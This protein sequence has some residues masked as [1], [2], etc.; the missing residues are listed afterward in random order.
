MPSP[1]ANAAFYFAGH[2]FRTAGDMV[3]GRQSASGGLLK[4][5][6]RHG[7]TET[8]CGYVD[9]PAGQKEFL[10]FGTE[11]GAPPDR[12][13]TYLPLQVA[14]LA[15]I[16]TLF[17]PGP[18]LGPLAWMRRQFDPAGFNLVGITHTVSD[19][20]ALDAL[21][22]LLVAPLEPWDA[23]VCTSASVEAVVRRVLDD[24]AGYLEE[25][26]GRRPTLPR[27]PII[28]LGV[29]A[30]ALAARGGN[31][32]VRADLR[33]RMNIANE[34]IAILYAGR[35]DHVE[36]ANP[37]P[38]LLAAEWAAKASVRKLHL[39]QAGQ[40]STPEMAA[41]FKKAATALA[42]GVTH[43]FVDGA[44]TELYEGVWAAAD[45]FISL[46]DNIQESFGLTPV[47]AMAAGLPC[48]VS[49]WNG[50]R[51]TVLDG[52]QGFTVPSA[53]PPPGAGREL[54]Y[55]FGAGFA[56]H[57]AFAGAASQSTAVDPARAAEAL[58]RLIEDADLRG[59]MA[60]AGRNRACDVFDWHHVVRRHQDLWAELSE[61]RAAAAT[62]ATG[63]PAWP[64]RPDP[65]DVFR[66]H[67][68]LRLAGDTE[69]HAGTNTDAKTLATLRNA[70]LAVPLGAML[71]D[72]RETEALLARIAERA[73]VSVAD[74]AQDV[75]EDNNV[76][77]YLT[78]GWL[79]KMGLVIA[80]PSLKAD[81]DTDT[82]TP[83]PFGR[84]SSWK[85][86]A[87]D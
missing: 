6:I 20:F 38:M 49:D 13:R 87:G 40:A 1:A 34:D 23:L 19:T 10:A 37:V 14:R 2:N 43:H 26:F 74:L 65:F 71:L 31:S 53:A 8:I 24:W 15:E 55:F 41:A 80:R 60:T 52:K 57:A 32:A 7:G 33:R 22:E 66:D 78:L 46:S 47:E 50:Y 5:F 28:P 18:G 16:G 85:T 61:S 81:T 48:V 68:T 39:I 64:L 30:D 3:V 72:D 82:G 17:R 27:L 9:G 83:L 45:I 62:P 4:G 63:G 35:L 70:E 77:F 51:E 21:G 58:G 36:K 79:A 67:P 84:S 56:N 11:A 12:L 69:I 25:R 75:A 29:D 73:P 86:L 42:P 44:M 59:R 54:A 76:P